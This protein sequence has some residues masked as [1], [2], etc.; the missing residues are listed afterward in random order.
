MTSLWLNGQIVDDPVISS[1]ALAPGLLVGEGLF[2]TLALYDG[3]PFALPEHLE[4]LEE[5][6]RALGFVGLDLVELTAAIQTTINTDHSTDPVRRLRITVWRSGDPSAPLSRSVQIVAGLGPRRGEV[7]MNPAKLIT[8]TSIRNERSALTGHKSTSYAE[9]IFALRAAHAN[10]A[11]EA[12]LF[13][14]VGE[15]SEGTMTNIVMELGGELVTPA[16]SSGCLPGV[17]RRLALEWSREAGL[18]LREAEPGELTQEIVGNPTA[19]LGTLRNVQQVSAWDGVHL[20]HGPLLR[21]LANLF[22]EQSTLRA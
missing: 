14:S 9:N 11:D 16:L 4:R 18:P 10:G 6:S 20:E 1:V 7:N 22:A 21:A 17:T 5:S 2:E 12:A 15:L 3:V 8:S 13:N 19:L